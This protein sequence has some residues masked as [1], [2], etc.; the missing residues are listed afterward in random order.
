[1]EERELVK[2]GERFFDGDLSTLPGFL[3]RARVPDKYIAN[4]DSMRRTEEFCRWMLEP[5]TE[6]PFDFGDGSHLKRGADLLSHMVLAR[7]IQS[8]PMYMYFY[9]S[10]LGQRALLYSLRARVDVWAIHEQEAR[11]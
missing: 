8:H 1:A 7:E 2:L 10:I 3:R 4:P 11:V 5:A 9:R 6:R